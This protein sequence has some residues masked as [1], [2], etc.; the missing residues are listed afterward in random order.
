MEAF[1]E[2]RNIDTDYI[3]YKIIKRYYSREINLDQVYWT[4]ESENY[5]KKEIDCA[6]YDYYLVY[7]RTNQIQNLFVFVGIFSL[8]IYLVY[9][10][11]N[12]KT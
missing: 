6:V 9:Y 4:L 3:L 7:I 8:I 1:V 2:Y 10:W 11:C 12:L 5:S